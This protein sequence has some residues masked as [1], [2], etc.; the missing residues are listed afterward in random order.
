MNSRI[1]RIQNAK[2]S[3]LF[4]YENKYIRIF[5]SEL[6]V[7]FRSTWRSSQPKPQK[8]PPKNPLQKIFLIFWEMEHSSCN[9][10]KVLTFSPKKSFS[11]IFSNETL[12]LSLQAQKIK[13]IH[14]GKISYTSGNGK[15]KGFFK[16]HLLFFTFWEIFVTFTT[17]LSFFSFFS[18]ER[19]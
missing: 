7:H 6:V 16:F 4:S 8:I 1:F 3:M 2:F 18:L 14:P 15:L 17:I 10:K 9:K 13:E 11:Y 5:K 12:Q 19:F